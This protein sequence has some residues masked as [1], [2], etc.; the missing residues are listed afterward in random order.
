VVR[1]YFL[2]DSGF[3]LFQVAQPKIIQPTDEQLVPGHLVRQWGFVAFG[4]FGEN[5]IVVEI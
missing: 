3:P 2:T 1:Q 4:D 5:L